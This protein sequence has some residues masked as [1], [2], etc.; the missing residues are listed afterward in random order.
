MP[1]VGSF[2]PI[3]AETGVSMRPESW[4]A[5]F[6]NASSLTDPDTSATANGGVF[7]H[8]GSCDT[9]LLRMMSMASR[10]VSPGLT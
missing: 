5:A 10:T 3:T 8:T 1:M 4:N 6:I 9:P 7:L 2:G